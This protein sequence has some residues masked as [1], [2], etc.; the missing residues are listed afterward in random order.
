MILDLGGALVAVEAA[1]GSGALRTGSPLSGAE[2][3]FLET[4]PRG[5]AS[6]APEADFR[7]TLVPEPIP[8]HPPLDTLHRT[9]PAFVRFGESDIGVTHHRYGAELDFA[10][11]RGSLYRREEGEGA[12]G[13]VLRIAMT[14]ALPLAGGLPIHGAGMVVDGRSLVFFGTSEAGKTTVS[15]ASPWPVVSDEMVAVA[16][17]PFSLRATGFL[18]WP[19]PEPPLPAPLAALVELAKGPETVIERLALPEALRR[20]MHTLWV[21]P[22]ALLQRVALG[23]AARLVEEVPVYRMTWNAARPPFRELREQVLGR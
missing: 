2:S 13:I 7:L 16:G 23:V 4:L 22:V 18:R 5:S 8:G 10:T 20:V 17:S 11:G 15:R 19:G 12:L 14:A 9:A 3:R 6:A 21:P 1:A